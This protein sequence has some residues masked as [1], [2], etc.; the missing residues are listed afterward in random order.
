MTT[1]HS[2]RSANK[3]GF[4]ILSHTHDPLLGRLLKKLDQLYDR[5]P[6]V[7]HH[8]F[9]QSLIPLTK[10]QLT[11]NVS[12]VDQPVR[13][14]WGDISI[15]EAFLL[16]LEELYQQYAPDWFANLSTSCYPVLS[17]SSVITEVTNGPYD[18]YLGFARVYPQRCSASPMSTLGEFLISPSL[19][20]HASDV[21]TWLTA[22]HR[23]YV[24]FEQASALFSSHFGC[25]AGDQWFTANAKAARLLINSRNQNSALFDYYSRVHVPDKSYY[26]TILCNSSLNICPRNKRYA[27]WH[28]E[29]AHPLEL[30]MHDYDK[31]VKSGCHF[32]RKISLTQSA[33]L[34]DALD[35]LHGLPSR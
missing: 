32:A 4:V 6:I 3:I 30:G 35:Q 1:F 13:T 17:G 20:T 26:Q 24:K 12:I 10:E 7:I 16:S 5:P 14:R 28:T 15:V 27:N 8:D 11:P 19:P 29:G 21:E 25:F 18:A 23:R 33:T 34:L 2:A 9:T 22:C 31:M